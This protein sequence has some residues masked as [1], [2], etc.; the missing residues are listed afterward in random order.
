MAPLNDGRAF[1]ESRLEEIEIAVEI[2]EVQ[3]MCVAY[4]LMSG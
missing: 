2:A 4:A 1:N 3:S